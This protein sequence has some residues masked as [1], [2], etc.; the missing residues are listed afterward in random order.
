MN[1]FIAV[2]I[3]GTNIRCALFPEVG[4]SYI[5]IKKIRTENPNDSSDTPNKRLVSCIENIWPKNDTVLGICAAAPGSVSI[6]DGVVLLAPNIPGWNNLPLGKTLEQHFSVKTFINN[7]A[8][9]AAYG[10]WKKGAGIGHLNVIYFTISTGIGGGIIINGKP[11]QGDIGIATEVGHIIIDPNGPKCGC[12][13]YGHLEAF[14]SGTAIENFIRE[15][16]ISKDPESEY[17]Q[18]EIPSAYKIAQAANSGNK[19]AIEAFNQAGYY[20]GIGVANYLHIFNP[21]CVI[22]GG[23]VTQ[24][25]D[26]LFDPFNVSL[27]KHILN[28][29]YL[30]NLTITT[31]KLGDNAGLV[32]CVEF[33]RDIFIQI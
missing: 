29:E 32:G 31:A 15:K 21:S 12:G 3:G 24:S 4:D 26:L 9:L 13:Q 25:G 33:L 7:D 27:E 22:F 16:I 10:E 2:D 14:S 19:L 11:L 20:L 30:N 5:S 8:R 23:G 17:F 18:N 28:K 6:N 1:T